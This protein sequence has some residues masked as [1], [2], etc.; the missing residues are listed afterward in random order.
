LLAT[1]FCP[2]YSNGI[3]VATNEVCPRSDEDAMARLEDENRTLKEK[4]K[5]NEAQLSLQVSISSK[6]YERLFHTKRAF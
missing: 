4:I 5:E 1:T 2:H 3:N 6:F